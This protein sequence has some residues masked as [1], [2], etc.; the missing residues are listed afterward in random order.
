MGYVPV[1]SAAPGSELTID[2]RGKDVA[3][4]VVKGAFY[5]RG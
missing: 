5:Q 3:A 4:R 1:A 2:C